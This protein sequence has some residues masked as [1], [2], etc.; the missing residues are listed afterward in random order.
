MSALEKWERYRQAQMRYAQKRSR[1]K[2]WI[3]RWQ[4]RRF[5]REFC[6]E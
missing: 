6:A 4:Y 1:W 5:E 2:L 3:A